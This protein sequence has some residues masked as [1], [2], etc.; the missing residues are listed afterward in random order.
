M[1]M[2]PLP[3]ALCRDDTVHDADYFTADQMH[4]YARAYAEQR[5]APLVEALQRAAYYR[6]TMTL[7]DRE[8][9]E[10]ALYLAKQEQSK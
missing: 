6:Y 2:P 8:Q 3:R 7:A 4:A 5:C 9:V 10:R 1:T